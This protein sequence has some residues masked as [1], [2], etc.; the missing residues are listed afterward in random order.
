MSYKNIIINKK[1][2]ENGKD[3]MLNQKEY[4]NKI[5]KSEGF[6]STA[7]RNGFRKNTVYDN[8]TFFVK[9]WA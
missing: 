3:T 7:I 6:V 8:Y 5:G 2:I 9:D 1:V 4:S